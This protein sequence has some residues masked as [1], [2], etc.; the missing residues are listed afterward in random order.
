MVSNIPEKEWE[1][2]LLPK[3]GC[4]SEKV[5]FDCFFSYAVLIFQ[6][7]IMVCSIKCTLLAFSWFYSACLRDF[8][9]MSDLS[10]QRTAFI[11]LRKLL[12][13][14]KFTLWHL[15]TYSMR[16]IVTSLVDNREWHSHLH[17]HAMLCLP[18][19]FVPVWSECNRY[20][21]CFHKSLVHPTVTGKF[22]ISGGQIEVFFY[23]QISLR[24]KGV[25]FCQSGNL[26]NS[27]IL[28]YMK[29]NLLQSVA[30]PHSFLFRGYHP[31]A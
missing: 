18:I 22:L 19:H 15:Y 28:T 4:Y 13:C 3:R 5:Y 1:L 11:V 2:G 30:V 26:R 25:D 8:R 10:W 14:I 29:V 16:N 7:W 20:S 6:Q 9:R 17:L 12:A 27:P 31:L 21:E 23:A 24:L